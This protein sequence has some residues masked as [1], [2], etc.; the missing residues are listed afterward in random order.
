MWKIENGKQKPDVCREFGLV[1]STI[2]TIW[3]TT[4][5]II[6]VFEGHAM[7][8]KQFRKPELSFVDEALLKW[9]KQERSDTVPVSGPLL[10]LTFSSQI[11]ILS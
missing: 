6:S 9:F 3:Q 7:R 11:L 1:N 10:I 5:K 2:Q 4:A 8:I